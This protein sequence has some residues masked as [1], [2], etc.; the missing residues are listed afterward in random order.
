MDFIQRVAWPT[1]NR[2]RNL[3]LVMTKRLSIDIFSIVDVALSDQ[4]CVFFTTM[5]PIAPGNSETII[6][7]HYLNSEFAPYLIECL[8][9]IPSPILPSSCDHL[10]DNINSK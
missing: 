5:L 2:G 1:H 9:N 6:K 4:H 10:V 8:N 3:G 7:K